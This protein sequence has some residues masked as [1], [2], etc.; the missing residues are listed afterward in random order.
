MTTAEDT[1][2]SKLALIAG[3]GLAAVGAGHFVRPELFDG[4]TE[5]AFPENTRRFLYLNGSLETALGVGL[6]VPKTRRLAVVGLL[7]YGAYLG[8]ALARNR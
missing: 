3:V 6:I 8:A 5:P 1:P 7:A 2:G 4:I